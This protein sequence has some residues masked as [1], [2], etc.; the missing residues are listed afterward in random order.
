MYHQ[1][2]AL[3]LC[4]ESGSGKSTQVPQLLMYDEYGTGKSLLVSCTQPRG[5]DAVRLAQRVAD[6]LSVD[7]GHEVGFST[8]E[9]RCLNRKGAYKARLLYLSERSLLHQ[10]IN[11]QSLSKYACIVVDEAHQRNAETDIL[12]SLLK[13]IISSRKD[14]KVQTY[15]EKSKW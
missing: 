14:F 1:S 2:Q 6:E 8:L 10:I 9:K 12:L 5:S 13:G 3:I 11:D 15:I 4:G 7:I